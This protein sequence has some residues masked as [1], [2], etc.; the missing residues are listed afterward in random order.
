MQEFVPEY[1]HLKQKHDIM[2]EEEMLLSVEGI[3]DLSKQLCALLGSPNPFY[4]I[5]RLYLCTYSW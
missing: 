3:F 4:I 5:E 1:A 2:E